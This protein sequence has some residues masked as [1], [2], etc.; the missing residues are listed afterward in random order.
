MHNGQNLAALVGRVML[1][2]IFLFEG[3]FKIEH[4]AGT[5]S[6]MEAYH[7]P[8]GLL[9]FVILTELGGGLLVVAGYYTRVA[10]LGLF[11]FCLLTALFFHRDIGDPDQLVHAMKNVAMAGGFLVLMGFGPGDWSLDGR[12]RH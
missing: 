3:W 8:G 12:L 7:L 10:A 2:L 9:P 6:Y 5:V 11:G 1:A 4:Y